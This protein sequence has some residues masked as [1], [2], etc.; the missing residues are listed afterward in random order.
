MELFWNH[1]DFGCLQVGWLGV[2]KE[3]QG[4][5]NICASGASGSFHSHVSCQEQWIGTCRFSVLPLPCM[6]LLRANGRELC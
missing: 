3:S 1:F 6:M 4:Q 2:M 5:I